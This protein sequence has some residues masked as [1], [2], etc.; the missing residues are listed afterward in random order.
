MTDNLKGILA[1]L[2]SAV[3]FVTNDAIVKLVTA[4]LPNGQ[5][6]FLRGLVATASLA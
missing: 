4:E 6:I 3:G 5:I 1:M 2:A